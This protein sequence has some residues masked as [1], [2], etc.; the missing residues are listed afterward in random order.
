MILPLESNRY[1]PKDV[2]SPCFY[3]STCSRSLSFSAQPAG[4]QAQQ[5]DAAQ[6]AQE[7]RQTELDPKNG[8]PPGVEDYVVPRG[9]LLCTG[10][11]R[12]SDRL[13]R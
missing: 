6:I 13:C 11:V 12:F 9:M 1:G 3:D 7:R 10:P 2:Y 5:P 8:R 4:C